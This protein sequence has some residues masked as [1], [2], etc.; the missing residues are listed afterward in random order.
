MAQVDQRKRSLEQEQAAL[1][2][3]ALARKKLKT[4]DLPLTQNKR[5]AIEAILHTFKKKGEFDSLRKDAFQKFDQSSVRPAGRWRNRESARSV[6]RPKR[7]AA[8]SAKKKNGE[9]KSVRSGKKHAANCARSGRPSASASTSV[10]VRNVGKERDYGSVK[11]RSAE[12]R[13]AV[14]RKSMIESVRD[15]TIATGTDDAG[16]QAETQAEAGSGPRAAIGL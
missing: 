5:A 1:A 12:R 6:R 9:R 4:S 13:D 7:I 2:D 15:A 8:A 10:S 3:P 16:R 14:R 11:E